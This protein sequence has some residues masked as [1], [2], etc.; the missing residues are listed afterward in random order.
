MS[1]AKDVCKQIHRSRLPKNARAAVVRE[2]GRL[3]GPELESLK[4]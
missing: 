1:T 2:V 3:A 4:H